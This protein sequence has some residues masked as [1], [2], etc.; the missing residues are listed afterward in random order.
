[1]RGMLM[2]VEHMVMLGALGDVSRE[3][4]IAEA[5]SIGAM[6]QAFVR[7]GPEIREA[8]AT[9]WSLEGVLIG[10]DTGTVRAE[11]EGLRQAL[12][13]RWLRQTLPTL[14]S[15]EPAKLDHTMSDIAPRVAM[16]E[17]EEA[18]RAATA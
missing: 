6:L 16:P 10:Q 12:V 2:H 14:A 3:R 8:V 5:P 7:F 9:K 17:A 1:M 18:A 11:Y 13:C 4:R 15:V